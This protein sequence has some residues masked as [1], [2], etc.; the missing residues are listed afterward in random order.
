LDPGARAMMPK[1]GFVLG[2]ESS[3]LDRSTAAGI[4]ALGCDS[5]WAA[6]HITSDDPAT[7]VV[8]TV[9][10]IAALTERVQVGSAVLVLPL[11]SPAVI[12]KQ[13]AELDRASAG[14]LAM[15]VGT[16]GDL[17]EAAACG[18]VATDRGPR[19]DESIDIIQ[20]LWRGESV[21]RV[22]PWWTL[23]GASITPG[24]VQPGGPPILVAGHKRVAMHRAARLGD[25]WLPTMF[26]PSAFER[27]VTEI[28][29]HAADI[30]RVLDGFAWMCLIYVRVDDDADE[31]RSSAVSSVA[32]EMGIGSTGLDALLA[33][34]AAVGTPQEVAAAL[35]RYVDAGVDHLVIRCCGADQLGQFKRVMGEV[36]P[37]MAAASRPDRQDSRDDRQES[38]A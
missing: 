1:V 29:R 31:A 7:E 36:L 24:P 9:A 30:G 3:P 16:G 2:P 15:G 38:R 37:L 4:E 19:M 12:A 20:A 21:D 6:G 22:T 18:M 14:R 8:T 11:H 23:Q 27:S 13:F 17:A 5:L 10:R 28:T 34:T 33:R 32:A 35:Q 26:S 25:G